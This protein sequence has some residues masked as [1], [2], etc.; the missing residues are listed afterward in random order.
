MKHNTMEI[1]GEWII[2]PRILDLGTSWKWVVSPGRFIPG[3]EPPLHRRQIRDWVG[4]RTCLNPYRKSNSDPSA[5]Q[6]VSSRYTDCPIPA[7]TENQ[8]LQNYS[9]PKKSDELMNI[10]STEQILISV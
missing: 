8:M 9:E 6:P 7:S 1:Y 4:P 2:N 3:K 10:F 5:V